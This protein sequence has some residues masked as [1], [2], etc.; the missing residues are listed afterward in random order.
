M[1]T[2][3]LLG[4][5]AALAT[6]MAIGSQATLNA[7]ISDSIG[8]FRTGLLMNLAGGL[9]AG[10]ILMLVSRGQPFSEGRLSGSVVSML[11]V[12]GG[13]GIVVITGVAFSLSQTGVTAGLAAIFLGQ[14]LAGL[15]VDGRGW[16][17]DE[18]IPL[19]P[20]RIIGLLLM[21]V[22]VYLLLP[23]PN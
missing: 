11:F 15:I 3:L 17:L 22:A 18:P 8:P 16:G 4:A 6:G 9:L 23:R 5:L 1:K 7:R 12:A 2:T 19:D 14:M 10:V 20:I 21:S 13:L